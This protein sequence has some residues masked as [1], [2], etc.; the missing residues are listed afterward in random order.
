[1]VYAE[2]GV[3]IDEIKIERDVKE[4]RKSVDTEDIYI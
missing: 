4:P 1:M 3:V 2:M